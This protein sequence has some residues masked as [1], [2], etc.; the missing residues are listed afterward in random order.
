MD[1]ELNAALD[2]L[3][4]T[5]RNLAQMVAEATEERLGWAD[6]GAKWSP[7]EIMAHLRDMES[8]AFRLGI[9]RM[10]AEDG[11][12][13]V[14]IDDDAWLAGRNHG[15][16]RREWLLADFALQ[17]QATLGLLRGL[18]YE[19]WQ[20]TGTVAGGAVTISGWCLAQ[21][22][23]D[24]EHIARLESA[25]GETLNDVLARRARPE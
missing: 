3:A 11:P 12:A 6:D 24:A 14:A 22:G 10:L 7:R 1:A 5:P 23:R 17:R 18:R 15:R 16:D 21:A 9:E 8:L 2:A 25:L 4:S 13:L 20:R 19:E